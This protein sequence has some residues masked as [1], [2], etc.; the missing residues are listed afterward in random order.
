LRVYHSIKE[1][2]EK[3]THTVEF[4]REAVRTLAEQWVAARPRWHRIWASAS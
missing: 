3:I 2:D 4:K 1:T